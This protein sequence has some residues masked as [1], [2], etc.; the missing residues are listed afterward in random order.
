MDCNILLM[1]VCEVNNKHANYCDRLIFY[2]MFE[3][4]YHIIYIV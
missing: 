2:G 3:I 1:A 4:Y